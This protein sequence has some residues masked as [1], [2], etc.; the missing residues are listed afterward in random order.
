MKKLNTLIIALAV[1][2]SAGVAIA[3]EA[4]KSATEAAAPKQSTITGEV[5]ELTCYSTMG[6]KG[7]AHKSCA[8]TCAKNGHDLGL[9]ED[10][11][12]KLYTVIAAMEKNPQKMLLDHVAEH[13]T[14]KGTIL[15]KGGMAIINMESIEKVKN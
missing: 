9:L 2:I 12:N 4:Q 8:I 3:Q 7:E 15:D 1:I 6:A 11:T 10:G 14:V 13:V 5:V